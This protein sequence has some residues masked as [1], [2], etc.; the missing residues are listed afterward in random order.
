MKVTCGTDIIE[1]ERI[2]NGIEKLGQKFLRKIYT[3]K[4]IEYCEGKN[5]AKYEHYA[6]RFAAKEATLKALTPY[7]KS[8]YDLT[9]KDM[10]IL[11]DKEGRPYVTFN[12]EKITKNI[13]IDISL[14]HIKKY[15]IANCIVNG[16]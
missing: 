9:W 8:K 14:S 4:E 7:L 5:A 12:K 15:A 11:N 6:A 13:Q 16:T 1:V 10:E 3:K 2:K